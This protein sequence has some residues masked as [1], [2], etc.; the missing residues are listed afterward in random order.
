MVLKQ[1]QTNITISRWLITSLEREKRITLKIGNALVTK[2]ADFIL[3]LIVLYLFFEHEREIL[4]F[5]RDTTEVST[6]SF[7]FTVKVS[8]FC[9]KQQKG[10]FSVQNFCLQR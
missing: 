6:F 10:K 2:I 4:V 9:H 5:I 7:K 3:G 8:F 1:L